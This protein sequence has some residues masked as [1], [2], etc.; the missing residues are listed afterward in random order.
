MATVGEVKIVQ[1]PAGG[2]AEAAVKEVKKNTSVLTP[3]QRK[4]VNNVNARLMNYDKPFLLAM[5]IGICTSIGFVVILA[6]NVSQMCKE[7]SNSVFG[8]IAAHE[9][10][11]QTKTG[12]G[13]PI[14]HGWPLYLEYV[15]NQWDKNPAAVYNTNNYLKP[16]FMGIT[17]DACVLPDELLEVTNPETGDGLELVWDDSADSF[18]NHCRQYGKHVNTVNAAQGDKECPKCGRVRDFPGLWHHS[19]AEDGSTTMPFQVVYRQQVCGNFLVTLTASTGSLGIIE[20]IFTVIF[21]SVL[22][23]MGQVKGVNKDA[24]LLATAQAAAEC[25]DA[26]DKL[27]KRVEQLEAKLGVEKDEA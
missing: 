10:F 14:R 27:V 24:G 26:M 7:E 8:D 21:V 9:V 19:T 23:K 12:T 6:S 4:I 13:R 15:G 17:N 20:T 18:W 2:A 25:D 22:T 5:L 11:L 3:T 16:D 1:Q